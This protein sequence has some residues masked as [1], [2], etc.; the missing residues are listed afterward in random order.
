[1]DLRVAQVQWCVED[2]ANVFC[3]LPSLIRVFPRL[4]PWCARKRIKHRGSLFTTTRPTSD[5]TRRAL[6]CCDTQSTNRNR[7][8][9]TRENRPFEASWRCPQEPALPGTVARKRKA[10]QISALSGGK[11]P[12][13]RIYRVHLT[14]MGYDSREEHGLFGL[15]QGPRVRS[16]SPCGTD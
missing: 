8:T 1:M 16:Q 6:T 12:K 9:R 5:N 15:G 10:K 13:D 3:H 14:L 11:S 2:A 4:F 7:L